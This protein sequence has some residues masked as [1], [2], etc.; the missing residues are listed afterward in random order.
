MEDG[1]IVEAGR[2]AELLRG[3][4]PFARLWEAWHRDREERATTI[5]SES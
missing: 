4:G 3:E 1:R 2:H 5:A